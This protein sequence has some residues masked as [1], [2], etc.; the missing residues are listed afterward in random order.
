MPKW[1][2]LLSSRKF[3][4]ALMGLLVMM[5]KA[6]KPDFPLEAGELAGILSVL[7]AYIL[8]TALEDGLAG[9]KE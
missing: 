2:L 3:W 9:H 1:K 5:V 4:A 8:G 6:W 7:V